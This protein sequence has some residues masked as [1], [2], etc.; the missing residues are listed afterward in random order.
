MSTLGEEGFNGC[1]T[2]PYCKDCNER[3]VYWDNNEKV[4]WKDVF[5][6]ENERQKL[7][8][9]IVPTFTAGVEDR[10][11]V[12]GRCALCKKNMQYRKKW[13]SDSG[14]FSHSTELFGARKGSVQRIGF[15]HSIAVCERCHKKYQIVFSARG[16]KLYADLIAEYEIKKVRK[17]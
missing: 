1:P 9:V 4:L 11:I 5:V 7:N 12:K 8:K 15:S 13:M 16:D 6:S 17:A 14:I 2:D 3:I 10:G